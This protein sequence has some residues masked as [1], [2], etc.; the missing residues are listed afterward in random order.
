MTARA[1]LYS[2]VSTAGQ[3]E[4]GVSLDAQRD[5]AE[6]YCRERG[7]ELA[8]VYTDVM[9]GRKDARPQLRQLELD[10]K[11]K[12]FGVV[13]VYRTDRLA[14]SF[15]KAAA[16]MAHLAEYN[17]ALVSMTEPLD[18]TTPMGKAIYGLLAGFAEQESINTGSRVRDAM[19]FQAAR[20][21]WLSIKAPLGYRYL[22]KHAEGAR[23][24]VDD[25]W[26]PLV[27]RIFSLYMERAMSLAA[28]A[29][30]LNAEGIRTKTG[31]FW[32]YDAVACI[33][34]NRAYTGRVVY[35]KKR[36]VGRRTHYLPE[37]QWVVSEPVFPALISDELFAR[38]QERRA[39]VA[40]NISR[41]AR[42]A[43]T[44]SPWAG[45][46]NCRSCR[47]VLYKCG[48]ADQSRRPYGY[49]QCRSPIEKCPDTSMVSG[50]FLEREVWPALYRRVEHA[51]NAKPLDP[52]ALGKPRG[53][54]AKA[55]KALEARID[56]ATKGYLAG[57]LTIEQAQ[58]EKADAE[59]RISSLITE[60]QK[61]V[62][63]P[64]AP[65]NLLED[66][67][68]L[69]PAEQREIL[70]HYVERID[71]GWESLSVILK[72]YPVEGWGKRLQVA[73]PRKQGS[74]KKR[75]K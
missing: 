30:T 11:A 13:L 71:V 75:E 43:M 56:R 61:V 62:P 27:Q 8:A 36:Q 10:A 18:L 26:A 17:V 65:P 39:H 66:W 58:A 70:D 59:A 51:M 68:Y 48:T 1:V 15:T 29:A 3:A 2:R 64:A 12:K 35:G 5:L 74:G 72:P 19:K 54:H 4:E 57:L 16:V 32:R 37:S 14:R 73:I 25:E 44:R 40:A 22:G 38:V 53:D 49:F 47:E 60:E 23:I 42:Y 52:A 33:L 69:T 67:P 55:I 46:L 28:I 9:S 24:E 20:G 63:F 50:L 21:H 45:L 7:W 41:R 6:R 31:V 34:D